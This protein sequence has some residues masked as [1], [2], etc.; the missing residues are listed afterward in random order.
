M[1]EGLADLVAFGSVVVVDLALAGDNAL[2]VGMIAARVPEERR[3]RL[4]AVGILAAMA[5]RIAFAVVAVELLAVLGLLLA[6]GLLLLWVAWKMW[7]ELKAAERESAA[8]TP[9]HPAPPLKSSSAAVLQIV[10]AD[11][12]MSLDN[13]LA[14]AGTAR[15]N[16]W[17]LAFG[18]LLSVLLMGLAAGLVARLI[19]RHAWLNYLGIAIVAA[20]AVS[21]I[22]E[23]V[24][25]LM[26]AV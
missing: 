17:V 6:G 9:Q 16:V 23:G 5:C 24:E 7:R 8:A 10:V 1:T 4:I 18:L 13:V 2:V 25:Q 15:H 26:N 19:S 12:S 3:R 21:M 22:Y 11:V 20:V 14:V